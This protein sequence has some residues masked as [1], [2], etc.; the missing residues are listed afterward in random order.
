[1]VVDQTTCAK[2]DVD[3]HQGVVAAKECAVAK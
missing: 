3:A 1:M 2:E